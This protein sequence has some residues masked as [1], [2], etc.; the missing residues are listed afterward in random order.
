[1]KNTYIII[2][3]A[4]LLSSCGNSS[5]K[6]TP[7]ESVSEEALM[8]QM[9]EEENLSE[10]ERTQFVPTLE[11]PICSDTNA[12]YCATLLF[13]WDEGGAYKVFAFHALPGEVL[14]LGG[15]VAE[16]DNCQ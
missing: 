9:A 10:F 12:V 5:K 16:Q 14:D 7:E 8:E 1:M 11:F 15:E 6:A 13:A 4:L 3:M 2:V